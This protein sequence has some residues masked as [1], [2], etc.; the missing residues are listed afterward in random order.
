MIYVVSILSGNLCSS[1]ATQFCACSDLK[2]EPLTYRYVSVFIANRHGLWHY[3]YC[4]TPSQEL[5]ISLQ[6]T[7]TLY[8]S[9]IP[10]HISWN[11]FPQSQGLLGFFFCFLLGGGG[12]HLA[13]IQL[14]SCVYVY[15]TVK[16]SA[17]VGD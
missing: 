16:N 13:P 3:L 8:L 7:S 11:P 17:L 6:G 9:C 12:F 1:T 14:S 15:V 10:V 2:G 4:K 5:L